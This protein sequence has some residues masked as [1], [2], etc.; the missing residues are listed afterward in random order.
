[1]KIAHFSDLHLL[2]A[3]GVPVRRLLNKRL[4]GWANLRLKR[5]AIHHPAYVQSIAREIGHG[6]IDHVVITGDVTN[7]ALEGEFE[8]VREC[9]E[10]DLGVDPSRVT[11]VPG[12]HDLYTRGALRSRRF[13]S[14]LAPW[15]V[16]DL[17]ELALNVNGG[18][19]PAVKLRGPAAIIALST[20]VPRLPFVAAG[21]IGPEQLDRLARI[22]ALKEVSQRTVILALHHPAVTGWSRA[23]QHLEGL[24]DAPALLS[25]LRDL[26]RGLVLHGHLHRRVQRLIETP[27]GTI[28]QVGATSASLHHDAPDRMA[29]FNLYEIEDAGVTCIQAMVYESRTGCFELRHVPGPDL[30]G[31]P[32][33]LP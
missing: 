29:G 5:G 24:R 30:S 25:V 28:R 12:N 1:M 22:L 6:D 11:L 3:G 32:K 9:L 7:L 19:F 33:H 18:R 23:K 16:S 31:P 13:E 21:E 8:L 15:L 10:R 20:A 17:P 2:A 26:P 27:N 4:T 14:F